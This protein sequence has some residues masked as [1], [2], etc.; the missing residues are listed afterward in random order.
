[1]SQLDPL[2]AS[3]SVPDPILPQNSS[4]FFSHSAAE[5]AQ[6][7]DH[8]SVLSLSS[9][10]RLTPSPSVQS[11][12]PDSCS[13]TAKNTLRLSSNN[14]NLHRCRSGSY[15][16]S[17]FSSFQSAMQIYS[18]RLSRPSSAKAGELVPRL[19]LSFFQKACLSKK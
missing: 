5:K 15:T 18:Q 1:M 6:V 19:C 8:H 2:T 16:V 12:A 9:G 4:Q 7:P 13:N 3:S 17:P 14:A 10:P 11:T